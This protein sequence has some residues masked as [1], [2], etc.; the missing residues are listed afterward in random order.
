MAADPQDTIECKSVSIQVHSDLLQWQQALKRR[1]RELKSVIRIIAEEVCTHS[2]D[3]KSITVS[4]P[5]S[6]RSLSQVC[7]LQKNE[8]MFWNREL[9]KEKQLNCKW[10]EATVECMF[11]A[12]W[13]LQTDWTEYD[14]QQ[15]KPYPSPAVS[16][17]ASLWFIALQLECVS[18][19]EAVTVLH[20]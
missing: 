13:Y 16:E 12:C 9:E 3:T 14:P 1:V 20:L 6:L 10:Q 19:D 4:I 7:S 2:T 11:I 8:Q 18:D 15:P 17:C 5:E